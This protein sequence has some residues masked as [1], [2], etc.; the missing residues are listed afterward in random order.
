MI[1]YP[2]DRPTVEQAREHDIPEPVI[3]RDIVRVAEVV[4]LER[5]GFFGKKSVLAGSM[6]LRCFGSPRFTVYDADFSTTT[7]TVFPHRTMK[8]LLD[9]ED[10][11]LTIQAADPVPY[12][13]G[14]TAWKSAPIVYQPR[15]TN[16]V[17]DERDRTFKADISFRGLV[18]EGVERELSIPYDLELWDD[19]PVVFVMDPHEVVAEKILGWC[20]NRL[21]KHYA[22]LGYIA[23]VSQPN[24]EHRLITVDYRMARDVLDAKLKKMRALQ[25]E[26]YAAFPH[27][28]ALVGDLAKPPELSTRQWQEIMYLRKQRDRFSQEFVTRAVREILVPGLRRAAPR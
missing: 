28:D 21:V 14:G 1:K 23:V 3:V 19:E 4:N 13:E 27:V 18:L 15:F 2:A 11:Q 24:V 16:L 10:D 12:D 25:P 20:A 26:R 6:A 17:P 8:D 22:D 5:K 7:D 9:Y